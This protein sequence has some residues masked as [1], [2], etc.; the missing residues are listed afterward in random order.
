[1]AFGANNGVFTFSTRKTENG[2]ALLTFSVNVSFS[3]AP[4]IFAKL[5]EIQKFL[6]FC[7]SLLD[8]SR[9]CSEDN[10]ADDRPRN[11]KIANVNVFIFLYEKENYHIRHGKHR[12]APQKSRIK[13]IC[14]VSAVHKAIQRVF[15][16]THSLILFNA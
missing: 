12:I 13:F 4:F 16:L 9:H 5:K 8:I 6:I 11:E 10:D 1:M 3:I 7:V 14:A 15:Y 2:A